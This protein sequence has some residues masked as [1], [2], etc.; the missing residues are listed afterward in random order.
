MAEIEKDV[1][2]RSSGCRKK[3]VLG[4]VVV[5]VVLVA[6]AAVVIVMVMKDNGGDDMGVPPLKPP[7]AESTPQGL[8]PPPASRRRLLREV[9]AG[10]GRLVQ[11][12]RLSPPP[13]MDTIKERLFSPGP[14][15]FT[16]R[17]GMVDDRMAEL[18]KRHKESERK[19]VNEATVTWK[20]PT[21]PGAASFSLKFSCSETMGPDSG[22]T[23]YFGKDTSHAYIAELQDPP[24]S[25]STSENPPPTMAVL[26][27]ITLDGDMVETWQIVSDAPNVSSWMHIVANRTAD[28]LEVSVAGQGQGLGLGCGVRLRSVGDLV[29]S[30]GEYADQNMPP[31]HVCQQTGPVENVCVSGI[32]LSNQTLSHCSSVNQ[33][34]HVASMTKTMLDTGDFAATALAMIRNPGI[35][36]LTNFNE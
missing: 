35:P 25:A 29:Y 23:V 8:V 30:T 16:N 19:C 36:P 2:V 14:T 34:A 4:F 27:S 15:D 1:P 24:P 10:A 33:F 11:R 12:R 5:G 17:L 21:F 31:G 3:R 32:D 6:V 22:L 9:A 7:V 18:N 20:P 26:A 28:M 13:A